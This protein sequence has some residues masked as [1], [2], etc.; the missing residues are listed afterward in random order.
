MNGEWHTSR[1]KDQS[2]L[3]R[4]QAVLWAALVLLATAPTGCKN[5]KMF[6]TVSGKVTFQGEPV[7]EGLVLLTNTE[8]GIYVSAELR[9]DGSFDVVTAGGFGLVPGTYQVAVTPPRVEFPSDPREAPPIIREHPNIPAKYHDAT[10]SEL[11]FNVKE[12]ENQL[13]VDMSP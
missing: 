8:Q 5:S 4:T 10:T 2:V 3:H 13:K 12:G 9:P 6:G 7:S 1:Q 11:T